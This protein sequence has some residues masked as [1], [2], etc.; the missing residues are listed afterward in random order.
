MIGV[1]LL[2]CRPRPIIL[3]HRAQQ[4]DHKI[5]RNIGPKRDTRARCSRVVINSTNRVRNWGPSV[6]IA[7]LF[8]RS[9]LRMKCRALCLW[10]CQFISR[11]YTCKSIAHTLYNQ[12][13]HC[14]RF[15]GYRAKHRSCGA[16][17]LVGFALYFSSSIEQLWYEKISLYELQW[18][19]RR[20]GKNNIPLKEFIHFFAFAGDDWMWAVCASVSGHKD[21]IHHSLFSK[22]KCTKVHEIKKDGKR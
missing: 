13:F 8:G 22:L 6:F 20:G 1:R 21:H 19:M 7:K 11:D 3:T 16:A 14:H 2:L 10:R 12:S 18:I 15:T 4:S 17:S 9:A 5:D